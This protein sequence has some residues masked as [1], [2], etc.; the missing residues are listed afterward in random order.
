TNRSSFS[1]FSST[2]FST[3]AAARNLNVLHIGNRSS[4]RCSTCLLLPVSSA[5]TPIRPPIRASIAA[6]RVAASFS[7]ATAF[8]AT[9]VNKRKLLTIDDKQDGLLS[10]RQKLP[11]TL[12]KLFRLRLG[13]LQWSR[14]RQSD[15]QL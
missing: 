10:L 2:R 14:G 8:A 12:R 15:R 9:K 7:T 11:D 1:F 6:I 13:F 3:A 4:A 5:A